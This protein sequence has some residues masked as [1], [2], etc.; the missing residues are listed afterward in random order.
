MKIVI[1]E[2]LIKTLGKLVFIASLL[3]FS[4]FLSAAQ[5]S[6]LYQADVLVSSQSEKE[7]QEAFNLALQEVL[8][9]V[10]GKVSVLDNSQLM[11]LA[12]KPDPFVQKFSYEKAG[13]SL[14]PVDLSTDAAKRQLAQSGSRGTYAIS[15]MFS[16]LAVSQALKQYGEPVWGGN[17]PSVLVWLASDGQGKRSILSVKDQSSLSSAIKKAAQIRGVPLF[18][19]S[20]DD[21]DKAAVNSSDIW[22]LFLDSLKEPSARYSADSILVTRLT[23]AD[24]GGWS[25]QWVFELKGFV[26]NGEVKGQTLD[27]SALTLMGYIAEIL[28]ERYAILGGDSSLNSEVELEI[29]AIKTMED[30]VGATRYI[31]ALPPV[32]SAQLSWVKGDKIRFSIT[33]NGY[34]EQL[35]QHIE[36]DTLLSEEISQSFNVEDSTKLYYRWTKQ[37][38]L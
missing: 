17:R 35:L 2:Y 24:G 27:E 5:V 8:V 9:R 11:D 20:M 33:L 1:N 13:D 18:L 26:Y 23:R 28:A 29:S 15:I 37:S 3:S 21:Q 36:L 22:G 14:S 19:P 25:G 12:K 16:R 32:S 34:L 4:G 6:G 38:A 30:Y 10:S 7:R 31:N